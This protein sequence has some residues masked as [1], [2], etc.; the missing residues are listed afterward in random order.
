[1]LLGGGGAVRNFFSSAALPAG[2]NVLNIDYMPYPYPYMNMFLMGTFT[3]NGTTAFPGMLDNNNFPTG[4][5]SSS[6]N[7]LIQPI[8]SYTGHWVLDWKGVLGNSSNHGMV[9]SLGTG[10]TVYAGNSFVYTTQFDLGVF[11]T[12]GS[13]EFTFN[14]PPSTLSGCEAGFISGAT[15]NLTQLRLY[16]KADGPALNAGLMFNPDFL[17]IMKRLNPKIVRM[18]TIDNCDSNNN[19]AGV[20]MNCL[21]TAICY[22]NRWE[23]TVWGGSTTNSGNTYSVTVSGA[24]LTQGQTIQLQFNA[25]NTGNVTLTLNGTVG[26]PV[27]NMSAQNLGS[28]AISA[29]SCWTLVYDSILGAWLGSGS[30]LGI[31][32]L[33]VFAMVE[34]C[35]ELGMDMWYHIPVHATDAYITADATYIKNN[36]RKDLNCYYEYSNEIWNISSGFEQSSWAGA[37]GTALGFPS[38]NARYIFSTYGLRF[39]LTMALITTAYGGQ[40]N[41][42]RVMAQGEVNDPVATD[43]YR[44]QGTDLNTATFPNYASIIGVSYNQTVGAGGNGRPIDYADVFSFANYFAGAILCAGPAYGGTYGAGD[45]AGLTGAADNYANGNND[46]AFAWI[47]ADVRNGKKNSVAGGETLATHSGIFYPGWVSQGATYGLP[48]VLYEGGYEAQAPTTAQC[49]SIGISTTYGG[50]GGKIDVMLTGYKYSSTFN[51]IIQDL[52]SQFKTTPGLPAG[53]MGAYFT[54]AGN[55]PWS[56]YPGDIY[57]SPYQSFP[58]FAIANGSS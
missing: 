55:L 38:S 14:V 35:N 15:I 51:Q 22:T 16:R 44:W 19:L 32:C 11:G 39:R 26:V 34:M 52:I 13:V 30:A 57:S 56:M 40:K 12:D 2:S 53:S 54:L 33:P 23:P 5:L 50:S 43:I 37:V 58:A 31:K 3:N 18:P 49:T 42:K 48:F 46:A 1:V 20:G 9:I 10:V 45:L 28:G 25:A 27:F 8:S 4:T 6:I 47:N 7:F 24:T 29:G 21:S 36:L 17:S 41:F